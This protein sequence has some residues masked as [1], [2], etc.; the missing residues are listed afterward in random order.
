MLILTLW[1]LGSCWVL[2]IMTVSKAN[3]ADLVFYSVCITLPP[4]RVLLSTQ[5]PP[6]S[7]VHQFSRE[8]WGLGTAVEDCRKEGSC[9]LLQRLLKLRRMARKWLPRA[10]SY[11]RSSHKWKRLP[12]LL[13]AEV[14]SG[15]G[16]QWW[17]VPTVAEFLKKEAGPVP[18]DLTLE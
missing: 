1:C 16:H 13:A 9:Q 10:L 7:P 3:D 2:I 8:D 12:Q 11:L 15:C 14:V 6:C 17:E 18:S 4:I 5:L